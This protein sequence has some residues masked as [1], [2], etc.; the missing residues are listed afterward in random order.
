MTEV[1]DINP[2]PDSFSL[3]GFMEFGG[4]LFFVAAVGPN[5]RE[6]FKTDGLSVTQ[7]TDFSRAGD[8]N[9]GLATELRP[10]REL[11]GGLF[12][13]ATGLGDGSHKFSDTKDEHDAAVREYL[14]R[15]RAARQRE[16]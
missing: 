2:G 10:F 3:R 5:R 12:F 11:G 16:Q 15:Q 9:L 4:E 8:R 1:A 13:V 6:V 7:V 14:Q